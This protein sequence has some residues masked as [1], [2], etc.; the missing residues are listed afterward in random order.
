MI[1]NPMLVVVLIPQLKAVRMTKVTSEQKNVLN[2]VD[3]TKTITT[4]LSSQQILLAL[5]TKP[6]HSSSLF[7]KK[8][9]KVHRNMAS[10]LSSLSRCTFQT[11]QT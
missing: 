3:T 6:T 4:K 5:K 2:N 8:I 9:L 10:K 7:S 1:C 11:D